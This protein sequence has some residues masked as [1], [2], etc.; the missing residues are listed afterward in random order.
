VQ[1]FLL[2]EILYLKT[3]GVTRANY[4]HVELVGGL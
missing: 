1:L 2:L 3:C 4:V